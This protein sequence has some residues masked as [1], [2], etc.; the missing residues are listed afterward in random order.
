MPQSSSETKTT[1]PPE[2][3]D[4]SLVLGGPLFQ[5]Y[6]RAHLSGDSLELLGLRVVVIALFAWLPLLCLS[7][8]DGRAFGSTVRIPFLS[9]AEA[10]ARFLVALPA[11]IVAELTVHRR[12]GIRNFVVRHIVRDE[13]LP[14]FHAAVGSAM[15]IRNSITV[16]AVL[17]AV[18]YTLGLLTWRNEIALG[19]ATWYASPDPSGLHLTPAGYWY[20]FVSIPLFQFILARWYM[21]IVLWV[22]LLWRI[23]RLNLRLTGAHP[24]HAGGIGFLGRTTYAFGPILFA[25]GALLSGLIASRVLYE[26]QSLLSF[27]MEAGG[28]LC[29][30]L[31]FIFGPLLMFTPQMERA[32]RKSSGDFGL[33]A[34]RYVFGFEEKWI[35]RGEPRID[36]LIGTSDIQALA[37]LGIA[38][39]VV[40]EM[41]IV[42]FKLV[43]LTRL[44]VA[45]AVPLLPLALTMFSLQELLA[46]LIK[47]MF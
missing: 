33:L 26:G 18:V 31:L 41:R 20:V 46:R 23:S 27:D 38:C 15:R 1:P 7:M 32:Q 16:E 29:A 19:T 3:P 2:P 14:E 12:V 9:D 42:P 22:R 43:D 24:D 39:S 35:R 28:L 36:D 34:H 10:Y 4:F 21:R 13:D 17:L 47:I 6:R 30:M 44:A 8:V 11:L 25:Q 37:D 45:T 40:S 5:L